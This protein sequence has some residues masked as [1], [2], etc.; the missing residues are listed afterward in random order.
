MLPGYADI[1]SVFHAVVSKC[2]SWRRS[3]GL[4]TKCEQGSVS[5]ITLATRPQV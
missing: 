5:I 2:L 4:S 3:S 1:L